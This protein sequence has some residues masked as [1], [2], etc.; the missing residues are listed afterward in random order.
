MPSYFENYTET[1]LELIKKQLDSR[2]IYIC[3]IFNRCRFGFPQIIFLNPVK[4]IWGRESLNYE[5]ISN[6]LW[7]TCPYLN[8]RIHELENA[9]YI[10]KIKEL[11][12]NNPLFAERMLDAHADYF[13]M[14]DFIFQRYIHSGFSIDEKFTGLFRTGIGGIRDLSAIKCLHLHYC[15]YNLCKENIA[16]FITLKLLKYKTECDGSYCSRYSKI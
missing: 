16:G 10:K 1:D 4:K 9:T 13:Y 2:E 7:L 5:A 3:G 11:I 14:R 8:K 6:I 15:H 12:Q